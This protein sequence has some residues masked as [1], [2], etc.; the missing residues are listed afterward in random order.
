[1]SGIPSG[2][3]SGTISTIHFGPLK[4]I[5][6][7]KIRRSRTQAETIRLYGKIWSLTKGTWIP[8]WGGWGLLGIFPH[9][10]IRVYYYTPLYYYP[11]VVYLF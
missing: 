11:L 10:P 1:M 9:Q 6:I 8:P 4:N 5:A 2:I 7:I 3:T